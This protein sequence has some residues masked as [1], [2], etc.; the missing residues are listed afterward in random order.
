MSPNDLPPHSRDYNAVAELINSGADIRLT[1][2]LGV[3]YLERYL[4]E[5]LKLKF[6]GLTSDLEKKL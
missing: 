3:G 4:Y 2:M 6:E 1:T 5:L